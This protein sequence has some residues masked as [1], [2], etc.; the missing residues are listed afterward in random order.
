MDQQLLLAVDGRMQSHRA[1]DYAIWLAEHLDVDLHVL[2]VVDERL[3]GVIED[4]QIRETLENDLQSVGQSAITEILE[5]SGSVT[6]ASSIRRGVPHREIVDA[7]TDA[8]LLVLGRGTDDEIHLNSISNRVI[9]AADP[10]VLSVPPVAPDSP[11]DGLTSVIVPTDGS[12]Y[13]LSSLE[14]A[15]DWVEPNEAIIHGLYVVDSEIY[16]LSEAPRSVIGILREGGEQALADLAAIADE[17]GT[18]FRRHIRRGDVTPV[19]LETIA[20]LEPQ[21]VAM[22]SRGRTAGL[23]PILGST[24]RAL[25]RQATVPLLTSE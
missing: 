9:H 12:D 1:T 6:V 22:G 24:T 3:L 5:R 16:D 25:L 21:L 11:Q 7:A 17:E 2:Y 18:T 8:D 15:I 14:T 4:D 10:P 23:D 19:I 13:A 20:E